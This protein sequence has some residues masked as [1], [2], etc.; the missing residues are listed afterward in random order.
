MIIDD[1][2]PTPDAPDDDLLERAT[3]GKTYFSDQ[4]YIFEAAGCLVY[5]TKSDAQRQLSLLEAIAGPLMS[6]IGSGLQVYQQ[7]PEDLQAI[8]RVHHHLL[9][10][11]NFAKG[12]PMA[13]TD[14]PYQA[15]FK[16]MTEAMLQALGV[17]KTQ[18]I[19]RDSVGPQSL[20]VT[21][22]NILVSLRF[23][24]VCQR[25]RFYRRRARTAV[26]FS[27]GHRI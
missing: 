6:G 23:L 25:H 9:A 12:F 8:L 2:L 18:R 3:S 1:K 7:S 10:L 13:S 22:A 15:P 17:M 27:G 20:S 19:I 5:I 14:L 16:Q 11:G 24:A 26:C 4:L 21:L